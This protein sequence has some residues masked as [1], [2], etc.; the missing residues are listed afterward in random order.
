MTPENLAALT[1]EA[2]EKYPDPQKSLYK[3][4]V[5]DPNPEA[6]DRELWIRASDEMDRLREAHISAATPYIE[7]I[8][9]N[10]GAQ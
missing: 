5:T 4:N 8:E 6:Y 9:K 1:R 2:E 3:Y 7:K 10:K